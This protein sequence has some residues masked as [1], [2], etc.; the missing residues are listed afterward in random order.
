MLQYLIKLESSLIIFKYLNPVKSGLITFKPDLKIGQP[1]KACN[2]IDQLIG[3]V[4]ID[5]YLAPVGSN[6]LQNLDP[7]R[8]ADITVLKSCDFC[9]WQ[10]CY[11]TVRF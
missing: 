5:R 7:T 3:R 2:S 4:A 9:I 8:L 11:F 10:R 1:D 6:S